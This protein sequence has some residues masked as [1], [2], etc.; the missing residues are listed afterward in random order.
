MSDYRTMFVSPWLLQLFLRVLQARLVIVGAFALLTLA[1]IYGALHIPTDTSIDRLIAASDPV[2]Q[3]SREFARVFPEAEEALI[4]LEAPDPLSA[5]VL[6]GADQLERELDQIPR[7]A[8]HSLLTLYFR[9]S[10]PAIL[11]PN[12]AGKLR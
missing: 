4:V 3:A 10:P 6:Q 5:A 2:A 1:G 7:V 8:A 11:G 9:S 12:E